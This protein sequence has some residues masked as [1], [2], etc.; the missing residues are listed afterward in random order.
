MIVAA[1]VTAL[2]SVPAVLHWSGKTFMEDS[3]LYSLASNYRSSV[4]VV[5]SIMAPSLAFLGTFAACSAFNLAMRIFLAK[6]QT[7]LKSFRVY[8]SLSRR[9]MDTSLPPKLFLLAGMILVIGLVPSWLWTGA[10]TPSFVH[11]SVL[12]SIEITET[13]TG[14]YAVLTHF[15]GNIIY[16]PCTDHWL[17]DAF[18]TN[19]PGLRQPGRIL[20]SIATASMPSKVA[21]NNAKPD[22]SGFAYVNRS[23]GVGAAVGLQDPPLIPGI[24]SYDFLELGYYTRVSCKYNDTADWKIEETPV[25]DL[26]PIDPN[27]YHVSGRRP[28]EDHAPG[29]F[30]NWYVQ[31]AWGD[32]AGE[33]VSLSAGGCCGFHNGTPPHQVVF[34]A[35][36]NNSALNQVRRK[37][38][39]S[40][41]PW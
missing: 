12:D 31:L 13:G 37:L 29:S 27:L 24:R 5:I 15:G 6:N 20:D 4:Q 1:L 18:Y 39:K 38:I 41:M 40:R 21:R 30:K 9:T 10:L 8:V 23:F 3:L 11:T 32:V 25:T 19:C 17:V 35:G 28:N 36:G 14:S 33:V 2:S 34:A 7:S 26:S 16:Y 22:N